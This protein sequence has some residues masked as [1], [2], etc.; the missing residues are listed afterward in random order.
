M[1]TLNRKVLSWCGRLVADA[2]MRVYAVAAFRN[3]RC[4][5]RAT[6]VLCGSAFRWRALPRL[7]WRELRALPRQQ[8]GYASACLSL[9]VVAANHRRAGGGIM[10]AISNFSRRGMRLA[11]G[12]L[13]SVVGLLSNAVRRIFQPLLVVG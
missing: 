7:T 10:R 1:A 5:A 6:C 12:H 13:P 4:L 9:G 3:N 11:Y 2:D 8:R